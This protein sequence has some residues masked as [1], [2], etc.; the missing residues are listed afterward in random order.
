[1]D[2][3]IVSNLLRQIQPVDDFSV[4]P[5]EGG[6]NNQV[7]QI[8]TGN[9]VF[10]LKYYFAH[11]NDSRDRIRTE[12]EFLEFACQNSIRCVPA[13]IAV[14]YENRVALYDF[15]PGRLLEEFEIGPYHVESAIEFFLQLNRYKDTEKALSLPLASDACFS[16][17]DH[18]N[19]VERRINL[20]KEV[21][22][23]EAKGFISLHLVPAYK[24]VKAFVNTRLKRSKISPQ[25]S[26]SPPYLSQSDFGFHNTILGEDGRLYFVDFEYAGWDS[27][28]KVVCDFFSQPQIA[29]PVRYCSLWISKLEEEKNLASLEFYVETLLPLHRIKWCCILLNHFLNTSQ[30]RRQ[31]SVSGIDI[32]Q[33]KTEQIKQ[34]KDKLC[35]LFEF[36]N[37]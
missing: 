7:F 9:R 28:I 1:M 16:I 6:R 24:L 26:I 17:A 12:Y 31:F 19:C 27:P 32:R 15:I 34:A 35:H 20:L 5:I 18:F 25:E 2:R 3:T 14:D 37:D 29:V 8:V 13:P 11:P 33:Q 4:Q 23:T 36:S 22:D 21:D 10:I 30:K